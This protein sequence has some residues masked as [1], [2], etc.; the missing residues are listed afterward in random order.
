MQKKVLSI[1]FSKLQN[2][3]PHC[4]K[5]GMLVEIVYAKAAGLG[6]TVELLEGEYMASKLPYPGPLL[7]GQGDFPVNVYSAY[8][9]RK[10]NYYR[11]LRAEFVSYSTYSKKKKKN[12]CGE[13]H[14]LMH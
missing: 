9:T 13:A 3:S 12:E 2:S 7:R 8:L 4:L 11:F 14:P 5:K 1:G 6:W 10:E